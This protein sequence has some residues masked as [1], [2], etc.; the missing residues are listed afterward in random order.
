[1]VTY[2]LTADAAFDLRFHSRTRPTAPMRV[3]SPGCGGAI[4]RSSNL[5]KWRPAGCA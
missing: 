1:M 3:A 5:A 2:R 4:R